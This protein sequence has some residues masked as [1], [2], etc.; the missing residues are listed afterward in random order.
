MNYRDQ[1]VLD[2]TG[3]MSERVRTALESLNRDER[4]QLL[5]ALLVGHFVVGEREV[6]VR[7][8]DEAIVGYLIS[9][10]VRLAYLLGINPAEA[11][12]DFAGPHYPGG[13][14]VRMLERMAAEEEARVV[15]NG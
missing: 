1:E 15:S 8:D 10:G 13:H 7:S 14:G 12:A 2:R 4:E 6:Q 3:S 5:H 11:P 9:P